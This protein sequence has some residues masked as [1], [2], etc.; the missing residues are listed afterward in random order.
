MGT[1]LSDILREHKLSSESSDHA[2]ELSG[3]PL[4]D[5]SFDGETV[6]ISPISE[7]EKNQQIKTNKNDYI[8]ALEEGIGS[9]LDEIDRTGVWIRNKRTNIA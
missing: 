7:F 6:I 2:L 1:V 4:A 5:L 9:L 8:S 3:Y